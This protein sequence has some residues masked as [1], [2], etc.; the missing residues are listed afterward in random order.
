MATSK[1][2]E[3]IKELK[4]NEIPGFKRFYS[5]LLANFGVS[6]RNSIRDENLLRKFDRAIEIWK[7]KNTPVEPPESEDEVTETSTSAATPGYL[8]PHAFNKDGKISD[9]Q[10]KVATVLGMELVD[11]NKTTK[12]EYER[13]L[14]KALNTLQESFY[15]KDENLS[16]GQKID[17]AM[18]EVKKH[19]TEVEKI[20]KKSVKVK[21][22]SDV[23]SFENRKR[24]H[25]SLK[26]INEKAIRLMIAL[27]DMKE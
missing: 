21:N 17:L 15:F 13:Q 25:S 19:L 6:S 7:E 20:I 24:I 3:I 1:V 12:E 16:P 22:E 8:I 9:K 5:N 23:G 18:R 14:D 10:R 11:D 27:N 26:R 2:L 4:T